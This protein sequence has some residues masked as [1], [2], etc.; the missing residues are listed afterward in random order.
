MKLSEITIDVVTTVSDETAERALKV[1]EWYCQ[2][3]RKVVVPWMSEDGE[4]KLNF[5]S[6]PNIEV[7]PCCGQ[8]IMKKEG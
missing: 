3:K 1:L 2:D 6:D 5:R 4:I 8:T 7:C